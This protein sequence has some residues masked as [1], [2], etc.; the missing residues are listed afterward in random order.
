MTIPVIKTL[1]LFDLDDTL[2]AAHDIH[3]RAFR[4]AFAK[5]YGVDASIDEIYHAGLTVQSIIEKVLELHDVERDEALMK[6]H[7]ANDIMAAHFEK[8]KIKV[9]PGVKKLLGKLKRNKDIILGIVTGLTEK[10]ASQILENADLGK[11]FQ[12]K[13]FGDGTDYRREVVEKA[14]ASAMTPK[15][16]IIG[17]SINDVEMAKVFNAKSIAVATGSTTREQLKDENP[18][19]LF[20]DLS[21]TEKIMKAVLG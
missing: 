20:D 9:L 3:V 12:I 2:V 18:D 10:V 5:V 14:V 1:V 16:V 19:F 8:R 6:L 11:Y 21:E 7:E 17:D 13:S 15:V 4:D